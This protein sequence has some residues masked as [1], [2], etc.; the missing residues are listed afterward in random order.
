MHFS[1]KE[2]ASYAVGALERLSVSRKTSERLL[3]AT[4][5]KLGIEEVVSELSRFG[6]PIHSRFKT[7]RVYRLDIDDMRRII[8][9]MRSRQV[10]KQAE[11]MR[12]SFA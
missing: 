5:A 6:G 2:A 11:E 12:P 1:E 3:Y 9:S 7:T 4:A 10:A 8:N